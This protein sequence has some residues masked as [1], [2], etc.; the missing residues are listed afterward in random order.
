[1]AWE[2]SR[3][4]V[5]WQASLT[6]DSLHGTD[7]HPR[8]T[9]A[10]PQEHQPRPAAQPADRDHRPVGLGQVLARLRHALRRGP[11]PLRRIA[12]GLRAPVPAADGKARRRPDRGPV[13]RDLDR[14]EG[15]LATT[16][17]R[18]S[19]PSPRS[20]T[21][22]ACCSRASAIRTA[23]STTWRSQAQSV[24]Q[25]VD[26]VLQLPAGHAPDDP[27]AG[28]RRAARASSWSCSTSCARRAS[29]ALRV[30]G[31]V[32]EIDALPKLAEEHASTPIEVVVD[33]LQG[34]RRT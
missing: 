32:H 14:A 1:M 20:T 21:T 25:M 13:A 34:P 16:R 28:G 26:H 10:Q 8:R 4:R 23:P 22:C 6:Q 29:C 31:K 12:V 17:A 33:R 19:A 27:R 18:R 2:S 11:A 15:D 3:N 9:H 24:A 7:P 30:D 5:Y